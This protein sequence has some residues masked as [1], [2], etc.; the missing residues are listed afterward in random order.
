TFNPRYTFDRGPAGRLPGVTGNRPREAIGRAFDFDFRRH[1]P[2]AS[3]LD[4]QARATLVS[5]SGGWMSAIS[6][7]P[8]QV[9]MYIC[10][11]LTDLSYPEIGKLETGVARLDPQQSPARR[12]RNWPVSIQP[13]RAII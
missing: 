11:Q 10:K 8:R 9:A 13:T 12:S 5:M 3:F 6:P 1:R 4:D 7:H 2:P